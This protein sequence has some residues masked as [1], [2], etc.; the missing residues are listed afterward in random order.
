M[1]KVLVVDD[2]KLIQALV[3]EM[4]NAAPDMEVIG[5]A[6]DPFE[7][8][9][10][11]KTLH[12]DVIT[13]DVEMPKMD[14][15]TFLKNLMRLKPM[16][17]VMLS[18][19]TAEGAPVTLE[20]LEVGAVDFLEKPRL[21]VT[22]ELPKYAEQLHEKIRTAAKANVTKY[23]P[24]AKKPTER[25][26]ALARNWD[27]LNFQLNKIVAI[28]ASTGGTEAIKEVVT[29]LPKHFSPVV[30]TQHIPPVFSTTF[31]KR[32]DNSSAMTVYEAEDGQKVEQGCVYLAPGDDHL[33]LERK[34]SHF[35]CKL[36]KTEPVNRH[37]PAVDV[38]F[39]SLSELHSKN[40]VAVLL[41]G[42]GADGALGLKRFRDNG[43]MTIAQNEES[44]VVY[45]MPK[46]AVDM[47]AAE[48]I[49]PL[50]KIAQT[51]IQHCAKK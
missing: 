4:I 14:G 6:E 8:R 16:P 22:A 9:E 43:A 45:G 18:T 26:H 15:I 5:D 39:D 46:A 47:G 34:G 41:T 37:R 33:K 19:L 29:K 35:Y 20:A 2:S 30:I 10:K 28:G 23:D 12:P 32:L 25:Q 38:M 1:I 27:N 11:I 49:L 42:M 31:A 48:K 7:A 17:V 13:L 51:L 21:N 24:N 44:C 3:T 36:E 50:D 40:C